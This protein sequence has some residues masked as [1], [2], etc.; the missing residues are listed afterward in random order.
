[1]RIALL[2]MTF[3]LTSC[4]STPVDMLKAARGYWETVPGRPLS[5]LP[6]GRMYSSAWYAIGVNETGAVVKWD[7]GSGWCIQ[8]NG[9]VVGNEIHLAV[10]D[11]TTTFAI[12]DA[13]RATV[14]FRLGQTAYTKQLKKTRDDPAVGCY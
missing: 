8:T 7:R 3:T 5:D 6:G 13:T 10:D 11:V 14:T 2:L 1:M 12:Q 9:Q 4:R